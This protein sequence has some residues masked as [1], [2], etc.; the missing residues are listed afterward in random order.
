[1][2]KK[3]ENIKKLFL[4]ENIQNSKDFIMIELRSK[5]QGCDFSEF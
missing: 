2:L 3:S 5:H 1:M 4:L